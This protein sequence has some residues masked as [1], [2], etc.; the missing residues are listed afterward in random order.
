MLYAVYMLDT[1]ERTLR[2]RM[3]AGRLRQISEHIDRIENDLADM[4]ELVT[5]MQE[6]LAIS[7]G[8]GSVTEAR[9]TRDRGVTS[10]L[11]EPKR[12]VQVDSASI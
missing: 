2:L 9:L 10:A 5:R 8:A 3:Y 1:D 11:W 6:G 12:A 7:D 4:Q